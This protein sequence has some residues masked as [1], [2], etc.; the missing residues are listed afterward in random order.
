MIART[1]AAFRRLLDWTVIALMLAIVAQVALSALDINPVA[2]FD[3]ALPV[4]DRSITLNSFLDLQ[5][6]LLVLIG[7][8]PAGL[9]WLGA[10]HVR[11]DFIYLARSP[12]WQARI[13]LIGHVLFAAPFFA[14]ML[15]AAW[16]F[17]LRAWATDEGSRN[18]GLADLWLIK[19]ALPLGLGLLAVAVAIDALR[20]LR[21][22]R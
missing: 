4:L 3:A 1:A 15:P 2:T 18:G 20:L 11:V 9:V 16:A 7:L 12:R 14:L 5:W 21:H 22:A 13:D 6:H 10:G 19:A 8:L 17:M